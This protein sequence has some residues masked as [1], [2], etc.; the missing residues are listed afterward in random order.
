M[1]TMKMKMMIIMIMKTNLN[2]RGEVYGLVEAM[3]GPGCGPV[4]RRRDAVV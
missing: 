2:E 4:A 3:D 1:N